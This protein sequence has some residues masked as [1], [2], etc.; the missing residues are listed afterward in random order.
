M[1]RLPRLYVVMLRYRVA[2][3]VV[4]FML[5]GAAGE[6]PVRFGARYL[7]AVL[8]LASSYVSATALNDLVDEPIDRVNH[9][10][11]AGR[12]LVEG[13]ATRRELWA[14]HA[15]AAALTAV[16]AIPLGWHGLALAGA[17]LAVSHA[18][19][20]GPFRL[21]YRTASAPMALGVAYVVVPYALGVVAAGGPLVHV[22][23]RRPLALY[24]LFV[25]RIVLKDFRDREGDARYGKP[26]LLLRFGKP[27]TC[28]LSLAALLAADG[29]LAV[30]FAPAFAIVAQPFVA[31][32]ALMLARLRRAEDARAEQ[33]AIGI[34]ARVGN[35]LLLGAL[36]WLLLAAHGAPPAV[37]V[38]F[39]VALAA[40]FLGSSA[41]LAVRP[42]DAVLGYKG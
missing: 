11:D 27:T 30:S 15:V 41:S 19:S 13:T 14:L 5:L 6:G 37:A 8:V 40:L 3:M 21:S 38:A 12:P 4:M 42:Q 1:K 34:G 24:L 29:V 22:V 31:A 32:I 33:V 28:G 20:A 23:A 9:P 36:A 18:Y 25:A 35:G 10:R 17:S 2:A 26:T 39:E 16:A 7:W